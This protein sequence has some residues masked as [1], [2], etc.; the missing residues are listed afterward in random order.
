MAQMELTATH[1]V[2][3]NNA[4]PPPPSDKRAPE[5]LGFLSNLSVCHNKKFTNQSGHAKILSRY[6]QEY[7]IITR[8]RRKDIY[9][10]IEQPSLWWARDS[11]W[12][13]PCWMLCM[14]TRL[15]ALSCRFFAISHVPQNEGEFYPQHTR[16]LWCYSDYYCCLALSDGSIWSV[17]C[18]LITA[19]G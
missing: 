2:V 15:T 16:Q 8:R 10:Y 18:S 7:R 3:A 14:Q 1:W 6:F 17:C 11:L 4:P 12:T 13:A 5:T 9:K 19:G